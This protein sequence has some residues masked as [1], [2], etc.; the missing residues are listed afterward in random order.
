MKGVSL[1]CLSCRKR[2]SALLTPRFQTNVLIKDGATPQACISDFGFS[3]FTPTASFAMPASAD[4]EKGTWTH[5]APELLFPKKFG[6][7]DGR[8]SKQADVYAFGMVVYEVL[9]GC[10]PFGK[11]GRR[12]AEVTLRIIK[13]ERPN[14]P[15]NT[16]DTGFGGGT[17]KLVEK[18]W[19]GNRDKRPTVED[20]CNHFRH[21]ART[22]TVLPPGSIK[23]VRE[24]DAPTTSRS[25]GSEP[26]HRS[27][28]FRKCLSRPMYIGLVLTSCYTDS[29]IIR[30]PSIK[31]KQSSAG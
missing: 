9:T 28:D 14:K 18:C 27:R 31:H 10:P 16:Q 20:I 25:S 6:L 22:S 26:D 29:R 13:G 21:V 11:E 24:A 3:T 12:F 15:E 2:R 17:W 5:M 8:V 23:L 4:E 7:R 1:C 30:P 19:N